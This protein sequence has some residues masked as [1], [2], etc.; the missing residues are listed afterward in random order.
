MSN[1]HLEKAKIIFNESKAMLQSSRSNAEQLDLK[2][3]RFSNVCFSSIGGITAVLS[4]LKD[5]NL[6]FKIS[7]LILIFGFIYSFFQMMQSSKS[8]KFASDGME[9]STIINDKQC[10]EEDDIYL[11]KCL[12]LTYEEKAK[13]NNKISGDKA[14]LFDKVLKN[15]KIFFLV[16]LLSMGLGLINMVFG[17]EDLIIKFVKF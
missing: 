13:H 17:L 6:F 12:A 1:H 5:G 15:L 4:F 8:D 7:L 11:M 16:S 9:A 14:E 10:N 3:S 2:I